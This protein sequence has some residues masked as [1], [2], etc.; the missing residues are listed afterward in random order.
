MPGGVGTSRT[1]E[2]EAHSAYG[3]RNDRES[4]WCYRVLRL[5]DWVWRMLD[6]EHREGRPTGPNSTISKDGLVVGEYWSVFEGVRVT[7]AVTSVYFIQHLDLL[8]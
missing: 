5:V 4:R 3:I 6:S 1:A 7:M 8:E 2:S